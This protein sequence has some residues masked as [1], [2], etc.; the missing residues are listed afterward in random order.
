MTSVTQFLPGA[1]DGDLAFGGIGRREDK[2]NPMA[3]AEAS[4]QLD[5]E[6]LADA[7]SRKFHWDED[8]LTD[9]DAE[10]EDDPKFS[11]DGVD[12]SAKPN[13]PVTVSE[14]VRV[15]RFS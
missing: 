11:S 7:E 12:A 1:D 6:I 15:N 13:V 8:G 2:P 4:A 5:V 9:H 3:H 14:L 10:G